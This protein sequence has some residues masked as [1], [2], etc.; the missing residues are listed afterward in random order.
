MTRE[1]L[2]QLV[3][4][5]RRPNAES[6]SVE[7][8]AARSGT[9]QRIYEALSALAN[10]P[11][12][13]VLLFGL[14]EDRG[15]EVTGVGDAQRLQEEV[16]HVATA[17]MEPPLRP[18]FTMENVEGKTVAA[19]E[20]TEVPHEQKPCFYKSAG[21]RR[22]AY[23]RVGNTNRVMTD[24]EVFGYVSARVQ[25]THDEEAVGNATLGHLD[26][27]RVAQ[28]L[29]GLKRAR[30]GASYLSSSQ[31]FV[32]RQLRVVKETDGV[33]RPTLAGLLA[34]GKFPQE[35]E[36]QLVITFLQYYGV[37]EVEKAPRGERF[38]DNRKF[39]G[40]LPDMIDAAVNA[41]MANV[42][43]SS[44]IEGLFR[45]DI[46]EYPE[47]AVREA[48]VN[49]VGESICQGLHDSDGFTDLGA[50]DLDPADPPGSEIDG[51]VVVE[52]DNYKCPSKPV[53][54]PTPAMAAC[55][56]RREP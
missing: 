47:E 55:C 6:A 36:P 9:P 50:I 25:P 19:V 1:E 42:R 52:D 56:P 7:V 20:V 10:R 39:E 51:L 22:G 45:R 18:E 4:E 28:Y 26:Q 43:K 3:G 21:L 30:P 13:G 8:K 31:E 44:L 49:A 12:G 11:G 17:D 32:L 2:L 54:P 34:F 48:I 41:V 23:I 37:D 46:P 35:F 24:Y 38:L 29:A 40:P 33:L 16:G 15:F 5:V 27:E 53:R 14:D